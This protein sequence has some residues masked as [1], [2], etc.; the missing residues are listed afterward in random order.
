[1]D[2]AQD[3]R[4]ARAKRFG[5]RVTKS[6]TEDPQGTG[7]HASSQRMPAYAIGPYV[8]PATLSIPIDGHASLTAHEDYLD[9]FVR[10]P[11]LAFADGDS[12]YGLANAR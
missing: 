11:I 6:S 1:M 7:D 10:S 8:K 5:M 4:R 2:F 9:L 12:P 3:A